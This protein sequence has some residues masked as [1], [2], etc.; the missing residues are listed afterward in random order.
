MSRTGSFHLVACAAITI[1]AGCGGGDNG[2]GP[3][4]PPPTPNQ[5]PRAVGSLEAVALLLR[6]SVTIDVSSS[7][8]DPDGDRLTFTA[9]SS[10]PGVAGAQASDANIDVTGVNPG[11]ATI[12]VT[13]RD[14]GGLT[15]T[16]QFGVTVNGPPVLTDSIPARTLDEG[17]SATVSLAEH[18]SDPED[19]ALS[20]AAETSDAGVATVSVDG[21]AATIVAVAAGVATLTFTARDEW[22]QEAAQEAGVTV[23]EA[24]QAP[25]ATAAIPA[26]ALPPGG[27]ATV[28]LSDHFTD[29]DADELSF[30]GTTSDAGVA[31]VSI[32]GSEATV[33]GVAAG[34][35]T[36][37]FTAS[38]PDGLSADQEAAVTVNT[39]PMPEGTIA[40]ISV[41]VGGSTEVV[42]SGHFSDADGDALSYE[43]ASSDDAVA[44][45]SVAD[46]TMTIAGVGA[47]SATITITATDPRGASAVQ[48]AT[49]AVTT[50]PMPDSVPPT[51]DMV[52]G[53][54]VALDFSRYFTDADGDQLTYTAVTSDAT[55]ATA[56]VDGSVVTTT[57]ANAIDDSVGT[58]VALTVTATDPAGLSA[59]Q[60][61]AV[62]VNAMEYDTLTGITLDSLGV[63]RAFFA[64]SV[65]ELTV[66]VDL[67]NA[68][69]IANQWVQ[70]HWSEWQ[71]AAG[72][73]WVTA[74]SIEAEQEGSICPIKDWDDRPAGD[75]R[76]VGNMT[77]VTIDTTQANYGDTLNIV[78]GTFRTPTFTNGSSSDPALGASF[79][80][81]PVGQPHAP[82]SEARR[83]RS[84][85]PSARA[86][87]GRHASRSSPASQVL[88]SA[89]VRGRRPA[90]V[91]PR[92]SAHWSRPPPG[93]C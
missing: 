11:A 76:L 90:F 8:S 54:A 53:N 37:T 77:F 74:R 35:A 87:D 21:G 88:Q 10:N 60:E 30:E 47:G 57:A 72:T 42:V 27:E 41:A 43:A 26:Q 23:A 71:M 93:P 14:P 65:I 36:I 19:D 55:V 86:F 73:G 91:R 49:V 51:H 80:A 78:T 18:F 83:A 7:F 59:E 84:P 56:T 89:G 85:R 6:G 5:A 20:F 66:C 9:T 62:R 48:E 4:P 46:S 22:G 28:D 44:T 13:A 69:P 39:P 38:D 32:D 12:T 52:V 25:R 63:L 31:T 24:N 61:A 3:N 81:L 15:A 92:A 29:P 17:D 16:Q 67:S 2:T 79:G 50:P 64:G 68:L 40:G 70:A 1:M 34:T 82:D 58:V 45:A 33:A 75:Y